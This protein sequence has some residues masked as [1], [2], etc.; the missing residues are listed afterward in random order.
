[1]KRTLTLLLILIG[2]WPAAAQSGRDLVEVE[3]ITCW[4]RTSAT[5]IKTGEPFNLR[6]TCT[7]VETEASKVVAD[8]SKLDPT[9]VQ[10]PPFE[11]LDGTHAADLTAPGKRFFQYD[12]RLRLIAEDAFGGDV[13]VPPLEISYRVESQVAGGESAQGREQSY[14]LPA[15]SVRLISLVPDDTTD[16]REPAA[17]PF[18]AIEDRESRANL[19]Q[20]IAG[21]LFGLAAVVVVVMLVS[22]VRRKSAGAQRAHAHLAPRTILAAATR[23]LNDVQRASRGGWTPELVARTLAALRIAGTYAVGRQVG[24]RPAG[25]VT[26]VEGELV[27][28]SLGR[29][30]ML[31]SGSVTPE[32]AAAAAPHGLA[33]ALRTLTV[34]RYGRS[35]AVGDADEALAAAIRIARRQQS[36]HSLLNEWAS[37]FKRSVV[38]LRRKVW[39]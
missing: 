2:A 31:V 10:L 19:L 5:A 24:Q 30:K 35:E 37:N 15:V 3:P 32:T 1:M 4:W 18:T 13:P 21:V 23:E 29:G 26:P 9:V 17:M 27:I 38:D 20:T 39:A 33:D 8:F 36:E 6:L 28:G 11:V 7:V 12:Y 34:T 25:S 22:M 16:I 14:S